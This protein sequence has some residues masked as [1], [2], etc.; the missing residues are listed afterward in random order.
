M[1]NV[2]VMVIMAIVVDW[3][4]VI[5]LLSVRK[6]LLSRVVSEVRE[7]MPFI[8]EV[9]VIS[10]YQGI[11][12]PT[13]E[14]RVDASVM[15]HIFVNYTMMTHIE[16]KIMMNNVLVNNMMVINNVGHMMS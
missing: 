7:S 4:T 5:I 8:S 15:I 1:S 12:I 9:G 11:N 10:C 6:R 14:T 16:R 2:G 13:M 3:S